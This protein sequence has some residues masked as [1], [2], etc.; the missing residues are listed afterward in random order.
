MQICALLNNLKKFVI[1]SR[2]VLPYY[3]FNYTHLA[4]IFECK[5]S[6]SATELV[7]GNTINSLSFITY[8]Q[9]YNCHIKFVVIKLFYRLL[10]LEKGLIRSEGIEPSIFEPAENGYERSWQIFQILHKDIPYGPKESKVC[11][12]YK[13]IFLMNCL[14]Q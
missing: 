3:D 12:F 5:R 4:K 10:I 13:L 9:F 2:T 11:Y 8:V 1:K 14:L 6:E 7:F